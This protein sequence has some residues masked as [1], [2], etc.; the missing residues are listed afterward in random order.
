MTELALLEMFN[1]KSD[2]YEK[3][4]IMP[5]EIPDAVNKVNVLVNSRISD[6]YCLS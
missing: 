2:L 4:H 6:F 3:C 5:F 1:C